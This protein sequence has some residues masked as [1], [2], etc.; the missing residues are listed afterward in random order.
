MSESG[1]W[2]ETTK[3]AANVAETAKRALRKM[4]RAYERGTGC[5]IS[6]DEIACLNTTIVGQLWSEFGQDD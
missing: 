1:T 6:A 5:R 2:D 4:R 3:A